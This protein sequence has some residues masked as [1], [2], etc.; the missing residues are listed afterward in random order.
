MIVGILLETSPTSSAAAFIAAG[1][2]V[3]AALVAFIGAVRLS[4]KQSELQ[5][6][7][8]KLQRELSDRRQDFEREI[9]KLQR[10]LHRGGQVANQFGK[11]IDQLESEKSEVRIGGIYALER[12][13]KDSTEYYWAIIEILAAYI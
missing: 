10:E 1:G 7:Q 8:N 5:E 13:A 11:A 2:A 9:N 3:A 12:I 6:D 4:K